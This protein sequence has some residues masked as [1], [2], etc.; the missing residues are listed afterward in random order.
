MTQIISR[1]TETNEVIGIYDFT[2]SHLRNPI[3][4]ES[5]KPLKNWRDSS[6]AW[7]VVIN[8]QHFDYYTGVGHREINKV[9][10]LGTKWDYDYIKKNRHRLCIDVLVQVSKPVAPKFDSV[11]ACLVQDAIGS[12]QT[13]DDW[14]SDFGYDTDSRKA[15]QTYLDCQETA[16]KLRLARV[17]LDKE[18]ERLQDY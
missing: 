18:A 4:K 14:C 9:T 7:L 1:N 16:K 3:A 15:L 12:A 11:L 6:D 17:P 2:I 13:F 10:V 5:E 8:G